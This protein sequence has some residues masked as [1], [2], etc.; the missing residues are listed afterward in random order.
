MRAGSAAGSL[1]SPA[2]SLFLRERGAT[3]APPAAAPPRREVV[4]VPDGAAGWPLGPERGVFRVSG[5]VPTPLWRAPTLDPLGCAAAPRRSTGGSGAYANGRGGKVEVDGRGG[6][7][8]ALHVQLAERITRIAALK[9]RPERAARR[10]A[11]GD[12]AAAMRAATEFRAVFDSGGGN[13]PPPTAASPFG[14]ATT[15]ALAAESARLEAW[16]AALAA[17]EAALAAREAP[18]TAPLAVAL[19]AASNGPA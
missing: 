16:A 13:E 18:V 7:E 3:E 5:T 6:E 8:E 14:D 11:G 17:R 4:G 12:A 19:A 1:A 15:A 9:Q 10:D 2:S